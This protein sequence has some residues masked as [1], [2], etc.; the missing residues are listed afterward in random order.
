VDQP[1]DHLGV[2]VADRVVRLRHGQ[3]ERTEQPGDE[4]RRPPDALGELAEGRGRTRSVGEVPADASIVDL[5]RGDALGDVVE[6]DS[7][8]LEA[9][10]QPDQDD[11]S[12]SEALVRAEDPK[13][14]EPLD[15]LEGLAG[16]L[17]ELGA[18]EP[19]RHC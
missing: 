18:A 16:A 5:S 12:G 10:E 15:Q 19:A 6:R 2:V 9:G 1:G 8:L 13:A 11:V 17:G 7:A 14:D 4:L 3:A